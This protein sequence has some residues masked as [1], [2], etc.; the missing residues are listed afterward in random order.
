[1]ELCGRMESSS[2]RWRSGCAEDLGSRL[3]FEGQDLTPA[4]FGDCGEDGARGWVLLCDSEA[5]Q[6]NSVI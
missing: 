6:P 2:P 3:T 5:G 4:S 1:M